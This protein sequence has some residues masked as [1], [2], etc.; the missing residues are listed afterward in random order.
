MVQE[1]REMEESHQYLETKLLQKK[2]KHHEEKEEWAR[3]F[4]DLMHQIEKLKRQISH[5]EKSNER[6]TQ[7]HSEGD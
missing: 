4:K 3:I 5:L 7:L 6:L 1:R 2:E